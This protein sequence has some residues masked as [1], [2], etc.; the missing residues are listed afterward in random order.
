[1]KIVKFVTIDGETLVLADIDLF[2]FI[3]NGLDRWALRSKCFNHRRE[4]TS[5]LGREVIFAADDVPVQIR[6]NMALLEYSSPS[7]PNWERFDT[8]FTQCPSISKEMIGRMRR[9]GPMVTVSFS[10]KREFGNTQH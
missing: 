1:M 9:I 2:A 5:A 8:V 6:D 7:S 10:P 3:V 4:I